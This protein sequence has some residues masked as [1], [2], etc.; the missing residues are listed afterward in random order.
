MK[1]YI[2]YAET[3]ENSK[4]RMANNKQVMLIEENAKWLKSEQDETEVSLNYDVYKEE[5]SKDKEQS[6]YFKKLQDYDSK[7][8]FTSLHYEQELF[9]QDSV[10][11][12]MR[13]LA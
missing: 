10:L 2:N 11:R 6:D 1:N 12:E 9:T 4:A 8:T 13:P 5:K 7:L 3:L